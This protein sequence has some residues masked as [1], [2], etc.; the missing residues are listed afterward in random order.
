MGVRAFLA[1]MLLALLVGCGDGEDSGAPKPP[2]GTDPLPLQMGASWTYDVVSL[3]AGPPTV[4]RRS[5][6]VTLV[7]SVGGWPTYTVSGAWPLPPRLQRTAT[8]IRVMPADTDST[9]ERAIGPYTLLRLPP[10]VGETWTVV[11]GVVSVPSDSGGAPVD[12]TVSLKL[13]VAGRVVVQ[14]GLGNFSDAIVLT[15]T[16]SY[17]TGGSTLP[18]STNRTFLIVPGIGIVRATVTGWP[19]GGVRP[20]ETT[21]EL[22]DYRLR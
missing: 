8:E 19:F 7:E 11:D 9:F 17:G 12:W 5:A 16:M 6:Q 15:S 18:G 14:T 21:F 13:N 4:S 2:P 22:T 10:V 20:S 3:G 1:A